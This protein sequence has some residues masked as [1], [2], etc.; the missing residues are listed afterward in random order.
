M[1]RWSKAE[2]RRSGDPKARAVA[3]RYHDEPTSVRPGTGVAVGFEVKG[4]PELLAT[5]AD[6]G[7]KARQ[8]L[9]RKAI[10]QALG[11]IYRDMRKQWKNLP[12]KKPSQKRAR[13]WIAKA[14]TLQV[15]RYVH[16]RSYVTGEAARETYGKVFISYKN[17]YRAS[18][19]AHL[20]EN[21][22]G[23]Y[24]TSGPIDPGKL[25]GGF[26]GQ[27]SQRRY[28]YMGRSFRVNHKVFRRKRS[29]AQRIF[30][31][32][33]QQFLLGYKTK[34]IRSFVKGRYG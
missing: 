30:V 6:M 28:G 1:A 5:L 7:V 4:L 22:D 24:R 34:D 14:V 32:V 13:Y 23:N 8:S 29:E 16:S 31:E 10:R 19:L 11:P 18:K 15:D 26:M 27:K 9:E 25:K 33:T 12:V 2:R 17:K 20:L 3:K 21:P